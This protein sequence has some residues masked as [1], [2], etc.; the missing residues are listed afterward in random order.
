MPDE[1]RG[2]DVSDE[3]TEVRTVLSRAETAL[4]SIHHLRK[5]V[6]HLVV[7]GTAEARRYGI[8]DK[9]GIHRVDYRQDPDVEEMERALEATV[10]MLDRWRKTG[11]PR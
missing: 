3:L 4:R 5:V 10:N 6:T 7:N 9:P 1:G 11:R 8:V 2:R